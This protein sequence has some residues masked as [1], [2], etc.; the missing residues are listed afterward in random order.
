M[1]QRRLRY[2][3]FLGALFFTTM[4]IAESSPVPILEET[5]Q[6]IVDTLKQNKSQLKNNQQIIHHAVESYLLPHV[7]VNGMSRSVLG[8]EAWNA[9]SPADRSAFAHAFTQLVIRTYSA[10][11]AEYTNET[12]K[13]SPQ[14]TVSNGRF[15][16]VKS[17]II[18][19]NGQNI[20]LVY[21]LVSVNG[22]WKIY[23]LSVEGVSLLQSFHN[24]FG[25][26][27]KKESLRALIAEM[28]KKKRV[29]AS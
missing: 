11:L 6:K 5:A 25:E 4:V 28:D 19:G 27:L 21:S 24:Q 20:P 1:K 26:S 14:Y 22:Q 15:T 16:R 8:R 23:D 9:A 7:D 10:P 13:F 18:R 2:A 29:S 3:A 17:V 12:I